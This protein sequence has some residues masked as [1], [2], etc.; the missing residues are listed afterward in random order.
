MLTRLPSYTQHSVSSFQF[1]VSLCFIFLLH[2]LWSHAPLCLIYPQLDAGAWSFG[3]WHLS[4]LLQAWGVGGLVSEPLSLAGPLSGVQINTQPRAAVWS[5]HAA[6]AGKVTLIPGMASFLI[7]VLHSTWESGQSVQSFC[8]TSV[9]LLVYWR[10]LCCRTAVFTF[11]MVTWLVA[12]WSA[13]PLE[14]LVYPSNL[15]WP[16][17]IGRLCFSLVVEERHEDVFLAVFVWWRGGRQVTET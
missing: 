2:T 13:D 9:C 10:P 15:R 14:H 8:Q 16:F 17:F 4:K 12:V 11:D 5:E 6:K 3:G 1:S 7:F